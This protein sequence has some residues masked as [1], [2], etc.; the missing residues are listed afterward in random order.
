M[1]VA[2]FAVSYQQ[3]LSRV[4]SIEIA[5]TNLIAN[6]AM[7]FTSEGFIQASLAF[8]E[9]NKDIYPGS[10]E[11]AQELCKQHKCLESQYADGQDGL[12]HAWGL[13]GAASSLEGLLRGI[14][15][16]SRAP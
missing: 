6:R 5:A 16:T 10:Y 12:K 8:L 14:A 2:S 3:K 9:K 7:N 11:R 4:N 1:L 13:N 15:E